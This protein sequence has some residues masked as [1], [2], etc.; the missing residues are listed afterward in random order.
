MLHD[1]VVTKIKKLEFQHILQ[2]TWIRKIKKPD[3][4]TPKMENTIFM[5]QNKKSSLYQG[6]TCVSDMA[7]F[8]ETMTWSGFSEGT[9]W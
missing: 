6:P 9:F 3:F 8:R 7:S 5:G 2:K 1:L 4:G